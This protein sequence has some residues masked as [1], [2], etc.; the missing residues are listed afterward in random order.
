MQCDE[1]REWFHPGFVGITPEDA[2]SLSVYKFPGCCLVP[3]DTNAH[4]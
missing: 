1:C 2:E 3:R 4:V